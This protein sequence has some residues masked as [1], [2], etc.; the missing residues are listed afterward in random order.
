MN[1]RDLDRAVAKATGETVAEISHRG[2]LPLTPNPVEREPLVVDW[3]QPDERRPAVFPQ[4]PRR[5]G[6]AA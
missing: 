1:Q 3:D 2:F 6:N 4:R 5:D